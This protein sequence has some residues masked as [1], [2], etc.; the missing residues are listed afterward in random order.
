MKRS[1][2]KALLCS[3]ILSASGFASRAGLFDHLP[4]G[5]QVTDANSPAATGTNI[6]STAS[7]ALSGLSAAEL[8]G[9]VK[10]ALTQGV[11]KA[12]A[13]LGRAGGFSSLAGVESALPDKLK[14][15]GSVLNLGGQGKIVQDFQASLNQAAEQA[16]PAA[17]PVLADAIQHLSVTNAPALL[18][19]SDT[20]ATDYLRRTTETSLYAKILPLVQNSTAKAGVTAKYQ[21][22]LAKYQSVTSLGSL[23]GAKSPVNF[24]PGDIDAY[25]TQKTLDGLF[26]ATANEERNLRTNSLA[27]TSP[28][29]QKVF[30]TIA[31]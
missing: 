30:G 22:L 29:L 19:S 17:G 8:S 7:A 16:V 4:S 27:R 6:S 18:A 28:L 24:Q 13:S 1:N 23:F 3:L 14:K 25:I 26:Q 15:L 12:V 21:D 11:Q 9:G 20:A 2:L 10:A 31:H 5:L